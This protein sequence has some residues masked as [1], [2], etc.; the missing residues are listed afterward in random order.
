MFVFGVI[1]TVTMYVYWRY[2][3]APFLPY[4]KALAVQYP[5]SRPIVEGGRHKNSPWILRVRLNVDFALENN[6]P[7]VPRIT[8]T[9]YALAQQHQPDLSKYEEFQVHFE[10]RP[11]ERTA[12]Y[13]QVKRPVR[14]TP[15]ETRP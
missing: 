14:S 11:P 8:E 1:L 15:V 7:Q 4:Q 3:R 2:H 12:Q 10:Y 13:L 6:P 9:V 5:G